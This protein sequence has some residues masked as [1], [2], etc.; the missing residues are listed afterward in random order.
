MS[1]GGD[2]FISDMLRVG[3][4]ENVLSDQTRYPE[5]TAAELKDQK[6]QNWFFFLQSPILLN[7]NISMNCRLNCRCKIFYW[8]MAKYSAGMVAG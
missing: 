3:G 6:I 1:V 2:T 8:W 7:K 5:V 4:F